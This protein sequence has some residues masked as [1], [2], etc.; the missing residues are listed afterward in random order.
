MSDNSA[1]N[2]DIAKLIMSAEVILTCGAG[3]VGKTTVAAAIAR[4]AAARGR[5]VALV[6][7]D[8]ARRLADAMGIELSDDLAEVEIA[9]DGRLW[10]SMIDT[11]AAW[12]R[13]IVARSPN[14]ETAERLLSNPIYQNI[15]ARFIQSHEYIA[16]ERLHELGEN[17][18]VDL[19]VVDTPPSG[20]AADL[21]DAPARMVEFFDG[22]LLKWL[23]VPSRSRLASAATK[24]FFAAVDL[25]LG[26]D[27]VSDLSEFFGVLR[28]LGPGFTQRAQE[29]EATLQA[30]STKF[31]VVTSPAPR[32]CREAEAF[33]KQL[34]QRGMVA[35]ALVANRMLPRWLHDDMLLA[36]AENLRDRAKR[37]ADLSEPLEPRHLV[38]AATR[39]DVLHEVAVSERTRLDRLDQHS[40]RTELPL[41][42]GMDEIEMLDTLG[43]HLF[44][45][46]LLGEPNSG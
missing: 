37:L 36:E 12:D 42:I 7:V 35:S 41:V 44:D 34:E 5:N 20:H 29:V 13:L 18:D 2:T 11:S 46:S 19:L 39:A 43:A 9:G 17:S 24:P 3:G 6:T 22:N 30:D 16:I 26:N 25:L 27:F 1:N 45:P 10:A 14:P 4:A 38:E 40:R 33:S 31:V 28:T 23:T 32:P 15:T 8:P 21:L